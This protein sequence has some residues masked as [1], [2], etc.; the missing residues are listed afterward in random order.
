MPALPE[1]IEQAEE[2]GIKIDLLTMPTR[3]LGD[4]EKVT[5]VEFLKAELGAPDASGR[6]RPVPI[7]NSE[8]V[9]VADA[10]IA[11][12]GQR[13][14]LSCFENEDGFEFTR[15]HTFDVDPA[16]MQTSVP[17]VFAG[18]DAVT[19]PA[20]VV[21]AIGAGKRAARAIDYYLRG[22]ALPRRIKDPE[23]RMRVATVMIDAVDKARLEP[24][25]VPV[26]AAEERLKNFDQIELYF[27]EET[28]RNEAR[29]CLRCDLCLGCGDCAEVCRSKMDVH[30]LMMMDAGGERRTL[31]DLLRVGEHC[32]G[33]GSCTLACP[34][35]CLEMVCE[36]DE[37]KLVFCG[38]ILCHHEMVACESCG[39][40]FAAKK[41]IQYLK[42]HAWSEHR[43]KDAG[44]LC[45]E[46]ARKEKAVKIV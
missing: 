10:V 5:G 22:E 37:C 7:K 3:I 2:E 40:K 39:K 31:T 41:Y 16:S 32:I 1:E 23:P 43:I 11:A 8:H 45:P 36:G 9:I 30:A 18:G 21:E 42:D 27:D 25:E 28:A 17:D 19:G 35:G 14:D 44:K 46:C 26:V 38:T 24:H 34:Q 6:R 13:A 4:G 29:R 33:C 12:I 20:T 15:W